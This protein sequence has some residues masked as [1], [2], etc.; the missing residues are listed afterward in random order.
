MARRI[1]IIGGSG[2]YELDGITDLREE[3][4]DTPFGPPSDALIRGCLGDAELIFLPR[5]GRGHRMSPSELPY[6]ANIWALKHAGVEWVISVSAVGSLREA[7][8]PGESVVIIDQFI[9]RTKSRPAT[10]FE[11]GIV[12]HIPFGDPVCPT[13]RG[14]LLQAARDVGTLT[15]HDG[16]TYVCMEGPAFSTRAESELYRSW[17]ASVVGMTNLPEAKLAREAELSYASLA[18]PTDYDCWHPHHDDVSVDAV[19]AVLRRNVEAAK[20]ILRAAI[21]YVMAHEGPA[22]MANALAHGIMTSPDLIPEERRRAL[23]PIVAKYLG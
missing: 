20:A 3:V 23:A 19:I 18:M 14:M 15:V 2:L 8:V 10:F 9:D 17:G 7:I 21:P 12:A 1:G 13:L 6:R 16:G 22:P 4:V 11:D 5:H